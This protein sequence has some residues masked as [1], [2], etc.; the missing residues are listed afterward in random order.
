MLLLACV[1]GPGVATLPQADTGQFYTEVEPELG[2]S[3]ANPACHGTAGRPLEVYAPGFHRADA[4]R[5]FVEEDLSAEEHQLNFDRARA[6]LTPADPGA[7]LLVTRPLPPAEGGTAHGDG[8]VIYG[9][10]TDPRWAALADWAG[11]E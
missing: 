6:F 1:T 7:S 2:A 5:T 8:L 4:D 10:R 11:V 3:C 9:D